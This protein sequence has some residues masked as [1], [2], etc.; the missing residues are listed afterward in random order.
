[1]SSSHRL[2]IIHSPDLCIKMAKANPLKALGKWGGQG[3]ERAIEV[4]I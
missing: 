2:L 1:M 3:K 4:L